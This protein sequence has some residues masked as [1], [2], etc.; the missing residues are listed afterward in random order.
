MPIGRLL[1][2]I[3]IRGRVSLKHCVI[4]RGFYYNRILSFKYT[5]KVAIAEYFLLNIQLKLAS[6]NGMSKHIISNSKK[7]PREL[8]NQLI[9][10]H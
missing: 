3:A 5:V 2:D 4:C 1:S 10:V 6:L 8:L 7:L 9:V